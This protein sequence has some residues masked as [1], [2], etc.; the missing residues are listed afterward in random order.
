MNEKHFLSIAEQ[1]V[2][3][4]REEIISGRWANVMPGKNHLAE[5]LGINKKTVVVALNQLEQEGVL[6]GQGPGRRRKIVLAPGKKAEATM[7]IAILTYNNHAKQLEYFIKIQHRLAKAGH[8]AFFLEQSLTELGMNVPRIQRMVKT[9]DADAWVVCAAS[10]EVLHWFSEQPFPV[11]AIFGRL[12]GLPIAG[13]KPDKVPPLGDVT[14]QLIGLGHRR[15]SLLTQSARRLPEPGHFERLFLENLKSHGIHTSTYNLPNWDDSTEG[16]HKALD[17]LFTT[18]PPT[19]LILDQ[20]NLLFAAQQ[21][22]QSRG[23]RVPQDVSLICTDYDPHFSWSS[24]SI[25]H[26][27]WDSRPVIRRVVN[28]ATN[29]SCGKKDI[30]QNRTPAEFIAGG[31]I[32]P[33]PAA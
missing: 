14:R 12:S 1:V 21:F 16:F 4:L 31:T 9:V 24:P 25:A 5:E 23:L 15:I 28:W 29:I 32:G 17:A 20:A 10:S 26:I 19:A 22:L 6:E 18:T 33:A 30:R 13:A 2:E 11:L 8:Q 27:Y 3:H 7:K